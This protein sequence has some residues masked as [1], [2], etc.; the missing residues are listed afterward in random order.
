MPTVLRQDIKSTILVSGGYSRTGPQTGGIVQPALAHGAIRI[1]G[2]AN[3]PTLIDG[4]GATMVAGGVGGVGAHYRLRAGVRFGA[5]LLPDTTSGGKKV[6]FIPAPPT[7]D[8]SLYLPYCDNYITSAIVPPGVNAVFTDNLS[9]CAFY[10]AT[11]G[12]DLIVFH[13]NARRTQGTGGDAAAT[14]LMHNMRDAAMLDYAGWLGQAVVYAGGVE[15]ATYFTNAITAY[16]TRMTGQG[17]TDVSTMGEGCNVIGLI[18][19]NRWE[20]YYQTWALVGYKRTGV[21]KFFKGASVTAAL[22]AGKILGCER[23]WRS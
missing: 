11:C 19:R 17:N 14:T 20:F 3:A 22:G 5:A 4:G 10:I 1:G 23:F 13:A 9:G 15:K 6:C 21:A 16:T 18:H 7:G 2:D 12:D 8:R